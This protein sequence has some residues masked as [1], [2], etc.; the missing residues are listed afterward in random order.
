MPIAEAPAASNESGPMAV[1]SVDPARQM[2]KSETVKAP[3]IGYPP[4][5]RA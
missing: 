1:V 4:N 5:R 3:L 2:V